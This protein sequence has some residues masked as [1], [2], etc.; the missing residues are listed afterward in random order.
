MELLLFNITYYLHF[1]QSL[2]GN[3]FL[4][5]LGHH[6]QPSLVK[7]WNFSFQLAHETPET[8]KV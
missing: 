6:G 2:G 1:I 8:L 7:L 3:S 5:I 4:S